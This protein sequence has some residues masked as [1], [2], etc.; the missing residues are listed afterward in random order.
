MQSIVDTEALLGGGRIPERLHSC[1]LLRQVQESSTRIQRILRQLASPR[2]S[3]QALGESRRRSQVAPAATRHQHHAQHRFRAFEHLFREV[4]VGQ[5]L[6]ELGRRL[7]PIRLPRWLLKRSLF[8]ILI[9]DFF[10][11]RPR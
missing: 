11:D 5:L 7:P 10:R 6:I 8:A 3:L 9:V 1:M 4:D 2:Q